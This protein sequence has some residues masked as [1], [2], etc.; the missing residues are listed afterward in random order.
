M[1]LS[2]QLYFI[3]S[4]IFFMIFTGN[5]VISVKNTKEYLQTESISK[6]QDTATT[7]G[8][9]LKNL[10]QDKENPEIEATINAISNSGFYKEIRLEDALF[11][12]KENDLV[13]A[14]KD[15]DDS[16]IW[17]VSNIKIDEKLGKIE[18]S[19]I[20]DDFEK[21]LLTLNGSIPN[22]ENASTVPSED[23]YTFIPANSSTGKIALD[24]KFTA[25]NQFEKVVETTALISLNK[26]ITQVQRDIQFDSVP[27]IFIELLPIDLEEQYT[28]ISDGWKTS[29]ILF[30][31]ANPGEAYN[32]LYEQAKEA[33]IY[34]TFMFILSMFIV[35]VFVQYLLK[36]LKNLENLA[37]GISEG[38]FT[39]IKKMP[40]T[41]EL[42]AVS[43]A[44]NDMS[45]KIEATISRLNQNIE[46][47][48]KK[49]SEDEVTAL[50]LKQTFETDMKQM[51]IYKSS[52]YIFSIKLFDLASF[53][54]SHT[55]SEVNDFI[56]QFANLISRSKLNKD[57]N[58]SAYR[59]FGSEFA[60]IA[61]DFNYE[62]AIEFSKLLQSKFGV[63]AEKFGKKDIAH[64]GGTPFNKHGSTIEMLQSANQAYEK[65][66]LIGQNEFFITN[67]NEIVKDMEAWRTLVS[68]IIEN[69][70]FEVKYIG[71]FTRC[72]INNN[73][74]EIIMQEAF[75]SVKDRENNDIPIGT[76]VSI[77]E[78]YEK[79]VD[80]DKKVIKKV[81]NHI[82]VNKVNHDIAINLSLESINNTAFIAWLEKTLNNSKEIVS[83][84][85]FSVTAYAVA[86]DIEKFKFFVDEVH[87]FGAK[88]IIKR[89][90]T[91]FISLSDIKDLNLD[92]LRLARE[93][94]NNVCIDYSKQS[95]IESIAEIS[96]L[97]NIKVLA[98]SVQKEE[99]FNYVKDLKLFAASR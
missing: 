90:E 61:K 17:E 19:T 55:S 22:E 65:A 40:R 79:I 66:T 6:A 14:S 47:M 26:I 11:T 29:A 64:I 37:N 38:R 87:R 84:L 81:I 5:F 50:P 9:V 93:Y 36:P 68:E 33:V 8:F 99:D 57:S 77:A 46:N 35:F 49:L 21:E 63:L 78:K 15:L 54:K 82:L 74:N 39:K 27:Q 28:E 53:A 73:S 20:S 67:E 1:T 94:T 89:Y 44:F 13:K 48:S 60:V 86:K 7:L 91:K 2:K 16:Q 72:S 30:V 18:T 76:F 52:G 70:Q 80:F 23:V 88:I 42:K 62:D 51:F 71:D 3:I 43:I 69:S 85:V 95:F 59:F 83:N 10:I 31:S 97:L 92:Y 45:N 96:A 58:I 75:T 12:I 34:A 56:K 98:E 25:T 41:K 4:I 24:I 32:K